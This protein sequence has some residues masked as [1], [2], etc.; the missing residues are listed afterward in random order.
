MGEGK[1]E[2]MEMK[3]FRIGNKSIGS[4]VA[5]WAQVQGGASLWIGQLTSA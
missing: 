2:T 5:I 3:K 4:I 1:I